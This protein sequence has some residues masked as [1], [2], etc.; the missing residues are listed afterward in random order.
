VDIE[1][2]LDPD[3][4][5]QWNGIEPAPVWSENPDPFGCPVHGPQHKMYCRTHHNAFYGTCT[6]CRYD[7]Q[8]EVLNQIRI[9]IIRLRK[10][11]EAMIVVQN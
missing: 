5:C 6:S 2:Q 7:E 11:M 4:I 8:L 10:I 1:Q 9:G 3:C